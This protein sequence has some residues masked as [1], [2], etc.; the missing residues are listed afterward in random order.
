M[1]TELCFPAWVNRHNGL[2]EWLEER[3]NDLVGNSLSVQGN[4]ERRARYNRRLNDAREETKKLLKTIHSIIDEGAVFNFSTCESAESKKRIDGLGEMNKDQNAMFCGGFD[5]SLA[6]YALIGMYEHVLQIQDLVPAIENRPS[7]G[8]AAWTHDLI[9]T[10]LK[11]EFNEPKH[12]R[13]AVLSEVFRA[14]GVDMPS[15]KTVNRHKDKWKPKLN[16]RTK[17]K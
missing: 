13:D 6:Q 8:F 14:A 17:A 10:R 15:N 7:I 2:Q 9:D 16:K 12:A 3:T 5:F 4:V 1:K 11:N